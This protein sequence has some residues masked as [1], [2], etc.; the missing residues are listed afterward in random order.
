VVYLCY[1][2]RR[3]TA[4]ALGLALTGYSAWANWSH[5]HD[6]IGPLAALSAAGMLTFAEYALRD[7]HYVHFAG[8][9]TLG[10][11]AAIISGSVVLDRVSHTHET[12]AHQAR[13]ANLPRTEAQ[14]ALSEATA[15]LATATADARDACSDGEGPA[16]K[17]ASKRETAAR[18]RVAEARSQLVGLGAETA[19]D[20]TVGILG[21]H[22]E[23]FRLATLL[24]LP[25]WL[26]LAAPIVLA[27]GFA[28]APRKGAPTK[29]KAKRRQEKRVR[30][31]PAAQDGVADW[32]EAYRQKHGHGPRVADVR[33]AFGVSKTTAWR[34]IR[35]A[36]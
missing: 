34:R 12:R 25:L 35:S 29:A 7:R 32:V 13:S 24:G 5:Y 17:A 36:S 27:Y 4:I 28:P 6:L 10:L 20:P 19:V 30:R 21:A 14:K 2:F 18:Q 1:L 8:L 33:Q 22:A 3:L 31:K 23:T 9:G 15:A 11:A 16:C 26:E